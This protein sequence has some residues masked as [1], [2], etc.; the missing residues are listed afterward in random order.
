[1]GE[2]NVIYDI[3]ARNIFD[4]SVKKIVK[5][6]SDEEPKEE[7]DNQNKDNIS[8]NYKQ[9][10]IPSFNS[11]RASIYRYNNKNVPK[12]IE[13]IKDLPE[14]SEYY[15]TLKGDKYLF[16]KNDNLL[17]FMSIFQ[18]NLLYLYPK[19]IFI[20]GTFYDAPKCSYQIVTIRLHELKEDQFYTV[21]YGIMTCKNLGSY[22]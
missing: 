14:E 16:Y 1:M 20:D 11:V 12:D 7:I 10:V 9:N 8:I 4:S 5:R 2:E 15:N 22:I 19:H 17:I 6:K 21:G 3:N 13:E 18:A